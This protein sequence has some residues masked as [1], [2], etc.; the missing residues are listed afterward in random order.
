MP[1]KKI[2]R[3]EL[4]KTEDE[5]I[6]FSTRALQFIMT[7]KVRIAYGVGGLLV[8]VILFSGFRYFSLKGENKASALLDQGLEQYQT[9]LD[10]KDA[11]QAYQKV[12]SDFNNLLDKYSGK[13]SG[14]LARISFAH[15]CLNAGEYDRAIELYRRALEDF[16]GDLSLRDLLLSGLAHSFA[17][18]KD[19]S[20]A[21]SYLEEI[22]SAPDSILKDEA[23]F[24]L[25]RIYAAMG[26]DEKSR[27][28]FSRIVNEYK[29]SIYFA[30]AQE[31]LAG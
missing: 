22:V 7:H 8:L 31:K 5:F 19:Y 3:K 12:K 4:L 9:V 11:V 17:G 24:H 27:D 14:K 30:L 28:A 25:G 1:K 16:D 15:I 13:K 18:K 20:A 10:Q 29:G 23:L 2:S 6:T 26:N 21:A